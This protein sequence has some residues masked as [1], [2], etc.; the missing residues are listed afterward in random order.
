MSRFKVGQEIT[1]SLSQGSVT[2]GKFYTVTHMNKYRYACILDDK[3][4]V[5]A[6]SDDFGLTREEYERKKPEPEITVNGAVYILKPEPEHEWKFGDWAR[7]VNGDIGMVISSRH[8]DGGVWFLQKGNTQGSF[9][10]AT[11]LTY[12]STAEIPA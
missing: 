8:T 5:C 9:I 6:I 12:I 11:R 4:E 1:V 7:S 2:R 10:S 3:S